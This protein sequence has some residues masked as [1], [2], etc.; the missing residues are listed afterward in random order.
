MYRTLTGRSEGECRGRR[1]ARRTSKA[2]GGDPNRTSTAPPA[3]LP[4]LRR[5][6]TPS[7]VFRVASLES[8][9]GSPQTDKAEAAMRMSRP[10]LPKQATLH[11]SVIGWTTHLSTVGR[12]RPALPKL[13]SNVTLSGRREI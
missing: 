6:G 8:S 11:L 12:A 9:E 4:E 10:T 7:P 5:S 3:S 2:P 1:F 13:D